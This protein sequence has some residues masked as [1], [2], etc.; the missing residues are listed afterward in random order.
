MRKEFIQEI[1]IPEGIECKYEDKTLICK[2]GETESK[3]KIDIPRTKIKV[4]EGKIIFLSDLANKNERKTIMSFL[5]HLRNIFRGIEEKF[6][7]RLESANVHFPMTVKVEGNK[8]IINNF[9]GE[10][11][12]RKA[13]ILPNVKVEIKGHEITVSSSDKEAA[14]QT[15]GNFEKATKVKGRDLRIFQDGVYIVK[16][17]GDKERA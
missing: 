5:A 4:S 2:K 7:Y 3:R 1:E 17:P 10:K 13:D 9:L 11:I 8:L 6:V 16:K 12:S 14:G 15:A